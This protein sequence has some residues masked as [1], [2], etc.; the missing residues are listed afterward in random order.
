M[1]A[2]ELK[3]WMKGRRWTVAALSRELELH[4]STIQRW[5][6]GHKIPRAVELALERLEQR[7]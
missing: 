6:N 1:Q 4:P 5:R 2:S 3:D 7:P